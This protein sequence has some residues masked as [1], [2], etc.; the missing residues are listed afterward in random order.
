M[1][2]RRIF[3]IFGLIALV[4]FNYNQYAKANRPAGGSAQDPI[5]TKSYADKYLN[6]AFGEL[7]EQL[8]YMKT[9]I[10]LLNQGTTR[11][12]SRLKQPVT[13]TLGK[14]EA[15]EGK[16]THILTSAPYTKDGR[17]MLP[18]RFVGEIM[19]AQVNWNPSIRTASYLLNGKIIDVTIG[20]KHAKINQEQITLD[21]A[22]ELKD[23]ST[24]VP[25]RFITESLGA[26]IEWKPDT[27]QIII[28]P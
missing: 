28:Y 27:Q 17:T 4:S 25:V 6:Q 24:M 16:K 15:R 1:N 9:Q 20:S 8:A 26:R 7:A 11:I 18:F 14:K 23:G 13:L 22:P 10:K 12:E 2:Y 5:V 3:I 19:N 21:T